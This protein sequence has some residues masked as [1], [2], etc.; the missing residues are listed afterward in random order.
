MSDG[1]RRLFGVR[2][3]DALRAGGARRGSSRRR[4][5]KSLSAALGG[6]AVVPGF[7]QGRS[8]SAVRAAYR[9]GG[10]RF[11]PPLSIASGF[12]GE[13]AVTMAV[14]RMQAGVPVLDAVIDGVRI[15]EEDP[16]DRSVGYGGLPNEEGV[17]QLGA[18]VMNGP[19]HTVG[20]V[21]V[22]EDIMHP[23]DL[24]KIVMERTDHAFVVAEGAKRLARMHGFEETDLLTESARQSWLSWRESLSETDNYY[25]P[26]QW[27]P[28]GVDDGPGAS[29]PDYEQHYGTIHC[30]GL[31]ADRNVAAVTSTSGLSYKIP[32]RVA[33]SPTPGAGYYCDNEVGAAGSTGRGEANLQNISS[34]FIVEQMRQ[35][36][37]PEEAC[38]EACARI[39]ERT[40]LRRLLDDDGNP[41]FSV[42]FYAL[43]VDGEVGS[44]EL[45]R[46]DA[47][48]AVHDATGMHWVDVAY[49]ID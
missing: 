2:G 35:G 7:L 46:R 22:L 9:T 38:L 42:R 13:P 25:T 34:F 10:A 37:S 11:Q 41:N 31:D 44:A 17:V 40:R 19:T 26:D 12:N 30:S 8:G 1:I 16:D 27:E 29:M 32:G 39:A 48:M 47:Q 6:V 24:A 18:G 23:S 4:F 14:E 21:S 20:A 36:R 5:V 28:V 15:Q 33:D 43:N 49:L 45:R 3:D